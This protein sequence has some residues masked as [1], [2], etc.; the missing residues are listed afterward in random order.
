MLQAPSLL[1]PVDYHPFPQASNPPSPLF[2]RTQQNARTRSLLYLPLILFLPSSLESLAIFVG[3][4]R[5][6][7]NILNN[8]EDREENNCP[9]ASQYPDVMCLRQVSVYTVT[10]ACQPDVSW[11]YQGRRNLSGEYAPIGLA[12]RQV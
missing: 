2:P 5:A 8:T 11:S 6:H 10:L 9:L 3:M 1:H 12:C 7:A 4:M